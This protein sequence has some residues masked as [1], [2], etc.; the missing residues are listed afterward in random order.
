MEEIADF[1]FVEINK[2]NGNRTETIR[3]FR[4]TAIPNAPMYWPGEI[5]LD[6]LKDIPVCG[7]D[8]NCLE[9]GS[10]KG[11][12]SACNKPVKLME[13]ATSFEVLFENF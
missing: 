3:E 5:P 6:Q 10:T 1:D 11:R 2:T 8:G 9:E 12:R 4:Y 7:F 13:N